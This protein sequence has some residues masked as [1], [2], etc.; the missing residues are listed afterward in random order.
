ML[1][2]FALHTFKLLSNSSKA[3]DKLRIVGGI[4][5]LSDVKSANSSSEFDKSS[6]ASA[7][8]FL[9]SLTLFPFSSTSASAFLFSLITCSKE[10]DKYSIYL[11][12]SFRADSIP[13]HSSSW[14]F[15]YLI[16]F[17]SSKLLAFSSYNSSFIFFSLI[18]INFKVW[19]FSASSSS[20]S[21]ITSSIS[22]LTCDIRSS[23]AL[24]ADFIC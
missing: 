5:S 11:F 19:A 6:Y 7:N 12:P 8:C 14:E 20:F 1:I 9:R 10:S 18:E 4:L 13:W 21:A 22:C 2:A 23:K 17:P 3:S 16:N 24:L 15:C